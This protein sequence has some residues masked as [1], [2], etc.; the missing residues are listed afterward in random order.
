MGAFLIGVIAVFVFVALI[1][2]IV[3][4]PESRKL[5]EQEREMGVG[6]GHVRAPAPAHPAPQRHAAPP[7]EAGAS[8]GVFH[9]EGLGTKLKDL[10]A[11]GPS[12]DTWTEMENLL[13]RADLGPKASADLVAR[14]RETY[15]HGENPVKLVR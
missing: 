9:K 1:F 2:V 4:R 14:V 10:F 11:R 7:R 5:K 15:R 13:L 6:T 12:D 8:G 3:R